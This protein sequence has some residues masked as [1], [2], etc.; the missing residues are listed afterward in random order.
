MGISMEWKPVKCSKC[1]TLLCKKGD[2]YSFL[3]KNKNIDI[4]FPCGVIKC[5]ECNTM[6]LL[7]S[8]HKDSVTFSSEVPIKTIEINF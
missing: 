3:H 7:K 4:A 5:S 6:F 2:Y 8:K 1:G